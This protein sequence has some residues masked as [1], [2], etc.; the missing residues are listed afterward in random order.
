MTS[1]I[2]IV[3]I[4]LFMVLIGFTWYR[5]EA[6]EGLEKV[7][8]CVAGIIVSWIFTCIL[9]SLSAR[10]MDYLNLEVKNEISKILILV[11]TP[12]NGIIIMPVMA[13]IVSGLKFEEI[14]SKE[15]TKKILILICAL[16]VISV[17]EV[18]YLK[19][20]QLGILNVATK[21]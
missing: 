14:D 21:M 7:I 8:F 5:L 12:I 1:F 15:A 16:I 2:I 10:G 6:Y 19:N 20:I 13:K 4:A 18:I 3:V 11:F 9:F 17:I